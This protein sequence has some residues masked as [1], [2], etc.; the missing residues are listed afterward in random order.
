RPTAEP[1]LL[2]L[3]GRDARRERFGSA[4]QELELGRRDRGKGRPEEQTLGARRLR[5]QRV[6]HAVVH[7]YA[8]VEPHRVDEHEQRRLRAVESSDLAAELRRVEH[9]PRTLAGDLEGA[10]ALRV[11]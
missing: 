11:A 10:E 6:A 3:A 7:A 2:A 8:E 5:R 1:G 9:H 4:R